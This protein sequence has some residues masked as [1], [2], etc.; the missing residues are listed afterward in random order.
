[1]L[2]I[3]AKQEQHH[4]IQSVQKADTQVSHISKEVPSLPGMTVNL[5]F[6]KHREDSWQRH[7]YRISL[8]LLA[9]EE[10]WWVRTSD[11]FHFH[12]GDGDSATQLN[13]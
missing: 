2:R 10:V 8:F 5:S 4:A 7:L 9:G 6:L 13:D 1:M 3:Q 12:D 11:R